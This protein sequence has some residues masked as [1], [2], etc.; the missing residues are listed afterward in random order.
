MSNANGGTG[1]HSYAT[2]GFSVAVTLAALLILGSVC[3]V[4]VGQTPA[5]SPANASTPA[6]APLLGPAAELPVTEVAV[7]KDGH[8]FVMHDGR[9]PTDA[10]GNVCVDR[11]PRAILGTFWAVSL[12]EGVRAAGASAAMHRVTVPRTA[13]DV[14]QILQANVG[15]RVRVTESGGPD[16]SMMPPYDARVLDLP[17]RTSAELAASALPGTPETVAQRGEIVLLETD[18]GTRAVPVAAIQRVTFADGK[19]AAAWN[20]EEMRPSLTLRLDWGKEKPRAEAHV[21]FAYVQRGLRWIPSYRVVL[22]GKGQARL[23][24]QATLV[25]ELADLRDTRVHLV[26][27][28]PS[29]RFSSEADPLALSQTVATLAADA[30]R[31]GL[32]GQS[33]NN[34]SNAIATQAGFAVA[35]GAAAAANG[36]PADLGPDV[37]ALKREEDLFVY[38]MEH[39]T[40]RQ[41]ERLAI[42]V[43]E[44]TM[45]Y[46]D[47]YT[48]DIP[49]D[50]PQEARSHFNDEQQRQIAALLAEPKVMHRARITNSSDQPLT[51]APALVLL[52]DRVLGQGMMTYAAAGGRCDLAITTAIE[53]G[54]ARKDAEAKRANEHM[55]NDNYQRVDVH[56]LLTLI[57]QRQEPVEVEV[58]RYVAGHLDEVGDGGEKRQLN[59]ADWDQAA[60]RN[61]WPAWWLWG[62]GWYWWGQVNGVALSSWT[63]TV[64]PGK[65]ADLSCDWHYFWKL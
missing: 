1:K 13:L 58:H 60:S 2:I 23:R 12:D 14:R 36:A 59:P 48:L 64:E 34:F 51:T 65:S 11:I 63:L 49:V 31:G 41:G 37:G 35:P 28:V 32:R 29:F 5:A 30:S 62:G 43:G 54:V 25:N 19:P 40:L 26:V 20:D 45:P 44:W 16:G 46:R 10:Q 22:D 52:N 17:K 57:N 15:A 61:D 7:F 50:T 8:A 39:V 53:V 9:L 56:G 27:G 42:T 38:T 4:A 21:G 3:A 6:A 33:L 18:Q 24:L 47:V 55:G